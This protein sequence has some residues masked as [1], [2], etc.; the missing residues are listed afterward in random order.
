LPPS[1]ETGSKLPIAK[2]L[3]VDWPSE[4]LYRATS[5]IRPM[6]IFA[7]AEVARRPATDAGDADSL[8]RPGTPYSG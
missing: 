3:L 5:G 6:P 8:G 1:R 4:L 2:P 7:S